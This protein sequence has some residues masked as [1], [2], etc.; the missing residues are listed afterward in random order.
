MIET[1]ETQQGPQPLVRIGMVGG[2]E[3][4]FIGEVHRLAM[5]I[6]GRF[7]LV[8]G[9][10]SSDPDRARRSGRMLR[11]PEARSY[12]SY[13][14]MIERE[15]ALPPEERMEAVAVVTPNHMH[16]PV[17]KAALEAGFHVI[18]DKPAT[19]T[20]DEAIELRAA[21]GAAPGVYALTHTYLG[22][23]MVAEAIDR[24]ARGELGEV[25]RI[26]VQYPQEWLTDP[27]EGEGQKQASWRTDPALS[28]PSGCFG[29]IGT[30]AF[31]L[32]ETIA[33][34]RVSELCADLTAHVE[35]RRLEDDGAAL[36]RFENGA[37]GVL[38]ASQVSPGEENGLRIEVFGDKAGLRWAQ[39]EPNTLWLMPTAAPHQRLRA[40]GGYLSELASARCRTPMGHPE[41]Y[42]EAFA[43]LYDLF[44]DAVR[45]GTRSSALPGIEDGVRG[46]A[47]LDA[48]LR[49]SRRESWTKIDTE[50]SYLD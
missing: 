28:G 15:L 36:L 22:Y 20:L 37:R 3:G 29:D 30:H 48:S 17:S 6:S 11:L 2:G 42:L 41:G 44:A 43:N 1:H 4:A 32:A 38:L 5:R 9:A 13:E 46:M 10:L 50:Q 23:P 31:N 49:S 18:S 34:V 21:V 39:E 40:G 35:G 45:T 19:R 24:V 7:A 8:C 14:A 33:G 27:V 25:R 12:P 26:V 47:F 16:L